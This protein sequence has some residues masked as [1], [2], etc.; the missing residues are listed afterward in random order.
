ME[1]RFQQKSSEDITLSSNNINVSP[2]VIDYSNNYKFNQYEVL[3]ITSYNVLLNPS[4][5]NKYINIS[6]TDIN[7]NILLTKKIDSFGYP[8]FYQYQLKYDTLYPENIRVYDTNNKLLD[9]VI[10]YGKFNGNSKP[11]KDNKALFY[12][13]LDCY[14]SYGQLISEN[15][16]YNLLSLYT[17]TV[18]GAIPYNIYGNCFHTGSFYYT[19]NLVKTIMEDIPEVFSCYFLLTTNSVTAINSF[20]KNSNGEI[21]IDETGIL[22]ATITNTQTFAINKGQWYRLDYFF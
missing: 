18:S 5:Q 12:D 2:I 1:I 7:E 13:G 6:G 21:S 8:L 20:I 22:T 19:E 11:I 15:L 16:G 3:G 14:T 4:D 17:E 9:F 10:E